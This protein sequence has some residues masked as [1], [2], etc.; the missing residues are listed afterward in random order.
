MR[1]V[2]E[3]VEVGDADAPGGIGGDADRLDHLLELVQA[4]GRG[5]VGEQQAVG[6]EAAVVE[7]S[8]KSPP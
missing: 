4:R 6:D 2:A 3:V 5:A 1:Q 8:P 7:G